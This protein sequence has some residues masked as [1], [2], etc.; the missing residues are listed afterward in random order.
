MRGAFILTG[1][2]TPLAEGEKQWGAVARHSGAGR[3]GRPIL[4]TSATNNRAL[5]KGAHVVFDLSE[6]SST[7]RYRAPREGRT[8]FVEGHNSAGRAAN[9]KVTNGEIDQIKQLSRNLVD[10]IQERLS[11]MARVRN[12]LGL[13]HECYADVL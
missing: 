10:T 13:R 1:S 2:S 6:F 11:Q 8:F 9:S 4:R 7:I 3:I 12:I 5:P